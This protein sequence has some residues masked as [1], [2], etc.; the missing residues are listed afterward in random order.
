MAHNW[1]Q[2]CALPRQRI[3]L[4]LVCV[5][6][7]ASPVL[8][9][10]RS[11]KSWALLPTPTASSS[12]DL[13]LSLPLSRLL[14]PAAPVEKDHS[15]MAENERTMTLLFRCV[16]QG[17][18]GQNQT[19]VVILA[20]GPFRRL[21]SGENGGEAIWANST[22]I[23]LQRL[24]YSYLYS[25]SR[26]GMVQLYQIFRQ[27]V[28]VIMVDATDSEDCF[29]DP[30]CVLSEHK[31]HGIPAWKI[32]SFHFW[33]SPHNPLGREWTLSPE[34]Y[35]EFEGNTYLG[36]SIEPQ[37]ARQTFI[38]HQHRPHQA[39]VL[40][41]EAKYFAH[42]D[43]AYGADFFDAA[44]AAA[45]VQFVAGVRQSVL[46]DYFPSNITNVGFLSSTKFYEMLA[47][48]R[49]LVG[50]AIISSPTPY[51]AL[52]LGVPF[53][54]PIRRWDED[55]PTDR[56]RWMAQHPT[57]KQLDPP[58][59]YN[60]FQG[61][62]PGF[63]KA[64]V[65]ATSTPIESFVLENMRMGAVEARLAAILET[66]WKAEASKLLAERQASGSGESFWL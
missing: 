55:N 24:G 7:L 10:R 54:N 56:T 25:D 62:K 14:F 64:V 51:E 35:R 65:D 53:I 13:D 42:E 47:E 60:V 31:P 48:S 58:Y 39:Y 2:F 27:L 45:G 9:R 36:Y 22:V 43:Y 18:C 32:F 11:Y 16:E 44:S 21:L 66:D 26:E 52:C 63:V 20:A 57:L 38:P 1:L 8:F 4:L 61:D 49:V 19:K 28:S 50:I 12:V 33:D 37:C 30:E 34:N 40:A 3:A 59:V 6:V 41:K 15:W 46:P 5:L 17:N 23:T 29:N